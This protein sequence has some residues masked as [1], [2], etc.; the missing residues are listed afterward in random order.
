MDKSVKQFSISC[1]VCREPFSW[2]VQYESQIRPG[3]LKHGALWWTRTLS[4]PRRRW[5]EGLFARFW[6]TPKF[7]AVSWCPAACQ[8]GSD[9]AKGDAIPQETWCITNPFIFV[10]MALQIPWNVY[11]GGD[12]RKL[13]N[14]TNVSQWIEHAALPPWNHSALE[15]TRSKSKGDYFPKH[16]VKESLTPF[17]DRYRETNLQHS[18]LLTL[19]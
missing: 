12:V 16:E 13:E 14:K 2:P 1:P 7:Q 19:V 17:R 6:R 8:G 15:K 9:L 11:T 5:A 3:F 18:S 10:E 4:I